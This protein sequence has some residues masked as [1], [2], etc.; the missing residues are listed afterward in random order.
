MNESDS[1]V[2]PKPL[3]V[4]RASRILNI[5]G[6]RFGKLIAQEY[7]FSKK[8]KAYWKC[9]CDC[10]KEHVA[11][12]AYLRIGDVTSCGC[13]HA[14]IVA[15]LGAPAKSFP[16]HAVWSGM[17]KRCASPSDKDFKNYGARGIEVCQE[18]KDSFANFYRDMG[19]C[20]ID[21][22]LER[23]D[24]NLGYSRENC[25]WATVGEQNRNKRTNIHVTINGETRIVSEWLQHYGINKR[26]YVG[27][28]KSGWARE[29]ALSTPV[30][31]IKG[32]WVSVS[33]KAG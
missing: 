2:S 8:K 3:K 16:E 13:A 29:A 1:T 23:T 7:V 5:A 19:Q 21:H 12:T 32:T 4:N 22:T 10:G 33:A 17:L 9:Q 28:L 15:L 30:T 11:P 24:N 31:E 14:P 27:R 20:P 6:Q 18:W 25:K 26:T